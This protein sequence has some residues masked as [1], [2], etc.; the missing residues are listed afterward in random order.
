MLVSLLLLLIQIV[1]PDFYGN[2][3][4]WYLVYNLV[5]IA[6][7]GKTLGKYSF[8]LFVRS[9]NSGFKKSITLMFREI[10]ILILLPIL[11][12]NFLFLSPEP[13]HDRISGTKVMRNEN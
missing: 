7:N 5:T 6:V 12:F 1:K 3:L 2:P 10:L 9:N 4:L 8:S 13:L 11:A